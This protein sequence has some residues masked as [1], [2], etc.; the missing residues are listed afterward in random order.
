MVTKD[1]DFVNS[2]QLK[3]EPAR[4][5]L[6]SIGNVSNAALLTLREKHLPGILRAI[7]SARFVELAT[8]AVVIHG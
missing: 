1:A 3:G 5:L 7:N 6:V 4:L 2:F 8:T